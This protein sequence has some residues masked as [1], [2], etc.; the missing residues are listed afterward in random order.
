MYVWFMN[1]VKWVILY[2]NVMF[3]DIDE[4]YILNENDCR[5]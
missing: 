2:N 5:N 1:L 4:I 3:I